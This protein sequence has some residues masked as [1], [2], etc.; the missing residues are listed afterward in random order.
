MC[1]LDSYILRLHSS[2]VCDDGKLKALTS[3]S[4]MLVEEQK[5]LTRNFHEK[6]EI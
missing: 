2:F 5:D 3:S 4:R 1:V 6:I